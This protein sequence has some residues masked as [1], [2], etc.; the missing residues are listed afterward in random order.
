MPVSEFHIVGL[1]IKHVAVS[2]LAEIG[3]Q[4]RLVVVG[5]TKP[6]FIHRRSISGV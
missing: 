3:A 6:H 4:E 1:P 2:G 5:I